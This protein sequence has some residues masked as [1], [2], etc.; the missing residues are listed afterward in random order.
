MLI[1]FQL[2]NKIKVVVAASHNLYLPRLV[3]SEGIG[4]YEALSMAA[5]LAC[6]EDRAG[7]VIDIGAN[8]GL[9]ALMAAS[10]LRSNVVAVEP[11]SPAS[12][13]LKTIVQKYDLPIKVIDAAVSDEI[14]VDELH[15]STQSDMSNS[16]NPDF[17]KNSRK[18]GVVTTTIDE[19]CV[20][21]KPSAIK[22]DVE[23]LEEKVLTGAQKTIKRDRPALLIEVIDDRVGAAL[24]KLAKD[25]NYHTIKI[26]DPNFASRFDIPDYDNSGDLRNWLLLPDQPGERFFRR[27]HEWVNFNQKL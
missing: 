6:A 2:P 7:S 20:R 8:V 16:L 13:V 10:G 26:G 5:F 12:G 19:I 27:T 21:I 18:I 11:F 9:Y 24:Q 22:I 14:G 15:I 3:S 25:H 23:T 17:R 4:K 1:S